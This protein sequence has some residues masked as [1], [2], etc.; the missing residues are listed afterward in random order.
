MCGYEDEVPDYFTRFGKLVPFPLK[1]AVHNGDILSVVCDEGALNPVTGESTFYFTCGDEGFFVADYGVCAVPCPV[2]IAEGKALSWFEGD[3]VIE[4]CLEGFTVKDTPPGSVVRDQSITCGRDGTYTDI[5]ACV[6]VMCMGP[7][8]ALGGAAR[9]N[10]YP[11]SPVIAGT[12]VEY[13]CPIGF[14]VANSDSTSFSAHCGASGRFSENFECVKSQC[15]S[16]PSLPNG[17]A[18]SN[19]FQYYFFEDVFEFSCNQGFEPAKVFAVCQSNNTW[20]YEGGCTKIEEVEVGYRAIR[21]GD[22]SSDGVK[23]VSESSRKKSSAREHG[24]SSILSV[25]LVMVLF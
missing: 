16:E 21:I 8:L 13:I 20:L 6:P 17:I 4:S 24:A 18:V 22:D 19:S 10:D 5:K 1:I 7:P 25:V 2:L 9:V 14:A 3:E 11:D 15:S 12:V 23:S